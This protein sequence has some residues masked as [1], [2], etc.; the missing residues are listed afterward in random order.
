MMVYL[1]R[2]GARGQS[3]GASVSIHEIKPPNTATDLRL[4]ANL[5]FVCGF[6]TFLCVSLMG[7][8]NDRIFNKNNTI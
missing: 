6:I 2:T 7:S 8:I 5:Q 4:T 3:D 1:I